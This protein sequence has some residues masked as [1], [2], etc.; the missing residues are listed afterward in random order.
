MRAERRLR[1]VI[2]GLLIVVFYVCGVECWMGLEV[3]E[4]SITGCLFSV[5]HLRP[6]RSPNVG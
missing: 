3:G 6:R 2:L 1:I 4:V 5:P